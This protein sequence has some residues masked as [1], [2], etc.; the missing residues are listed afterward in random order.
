MNRARNIF[1]FR[2]RTQPTSLLLSPDKIIPTAQETF[3]KRALIIAPAVTCPGGIAQAFTTN[4][5][6]FNDH[7]GMGPDEI[8]FGHL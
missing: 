1:S 5:A 3:M 6:F 2:S 7:R 8:Q 4:R